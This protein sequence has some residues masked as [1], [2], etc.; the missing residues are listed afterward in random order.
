[1][2]HNWQNGRKYLQIVSDKG[3]VSRKYKV[4]LKLNTNKRTQFQMEQRIDIGIAR[5]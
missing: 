2:K 3:F 1:M 5:K 4:S